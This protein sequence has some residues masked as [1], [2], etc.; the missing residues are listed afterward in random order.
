[1]SDPIWMPLGAWPSPLAVAAAEGVGRSRVS[2][3]SRNNP[4]RPAGLHLEATPPTSFCQTMARWRD[5]GNN[6]QRK[7]FIDSLLTLPSF[8]FVEA[9]EGARKHERS[10]QGFH[11]EK[12]VIRAMSMALGSRCSS[13]QDEKTRRTGESGTKQAHCKHTAACTRGHYCLGFLVLAAS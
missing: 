4:I 10:R 8:P 5:Q 12:R 9:R 1:M 7:D 13:R 11:A 2:V 6:G 3:L